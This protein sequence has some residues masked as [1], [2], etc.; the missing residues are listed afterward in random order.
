[1]TMLKDERTQVIEALKARGFRYVERDLR[2][3]STWLMQGP[4]GAARYF[5][6][7]VVV[8]VTGNVVV[9]H[10]FGQCDRKRTSSFHAF[11]KELTGEKSAA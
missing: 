9:T 7:R 1:M 10:P 5:N 8:D 4:V 6:G 3:G 11:L 2:V